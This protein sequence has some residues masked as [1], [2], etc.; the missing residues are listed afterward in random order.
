MNALVTACFW[1][2]NGIVVWAWMQWS[3]YAFGTKT[4]LRFGHGCN[5]HRML[6]EHKRNY[7]LGMDAMV[8][9]CSWNTNGII[10][11]AWM[12]WSLYAHGFRTLVWFGYG[13][14]FDR[15]H[16]IMVRTFPNPISTHAQHLFTGIQSGCLEHSEH[17]QMTSKPSNPLKSSKTHRFFFVS[18]CF[19]LGV[20][21]FK[22][23]RAFVFPHNPLNPQ[24]LK[25]SDQNEGFH[26]YKAP[27]KKGLQYTSPS[28]IL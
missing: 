12:L 27:R 3:P 15:M 24:H 2:P 8:T 13:C 21:G 9:V 4:E 26:N 20:Y 1:K 11:W 22:G 14:A 23:L 19:L 6:L 7:G 10:V 16:D 28:C 17:P 18:T 5:G 25:S